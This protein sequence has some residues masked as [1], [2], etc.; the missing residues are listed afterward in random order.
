M[1]NNLIDCSLVERNGG[2]ERENNVYW[3]I[4]L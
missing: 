1:N 4:E 2:E 3:V